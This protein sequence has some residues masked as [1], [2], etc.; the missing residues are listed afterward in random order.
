MNYKLFS[1][2]LFFKD[3]LYNSKAKCGFIHNK[4]KNAKIKTK[5]ANE[6]SEDDLKKFLKHCVVSNDR[7]KLKEK[8]LDSVAL[9]R[10]LLKEDDTEF[11]DFFKFYFVDPSLVRDISSSACISKLYFILLF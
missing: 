6:L 8:L 11:R 2:I 4:I 3:L 1:F 5:P 9:R 7:A 10:R